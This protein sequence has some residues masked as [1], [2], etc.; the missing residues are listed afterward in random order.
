MIKKFWYILL[1]FVFTGICNC[2][3]NATSSAKKL[4]VRLLGSSSS[5]SFVFKQIKSDTD[6]F[7]IRSHKNKIIISG[8][9]ANSMAMGLGYYIKHYCLRD[10]SWKKTDTIILPKQLPQ[11]S[12]PFKRKALVKNRFFLNY[13]TFGYTMVWWQW[14]DWER[15]ID[16]MAINGINLPLAITGQ[17]SVWYKVWRQLGLSDS[18]IRSYFTGPAHLP[19]HRMINID[20]WQGP[21]PMSWLDHQE[22]LQRRIVQRERELG[23]RPILPAFAGHVPEALKKVYPNA[24]ISTTSSW[25]G[26]RDCY[27]SHFLDPKDSLFNVIQEKFLKEQT[28]LY[29]TDHIYGVDPF[30]EIDPPS[31][32]PS[33]LDDAGKT[34]YN[35]LAKNDN[36]TIWVQM[37]WLFYIDQS[38]WTKPRIQA[39]LNSVPKGKLLLLDYFAENTEVW[40]I[41]DSYFGH[42]F[43]WC[44]LGNFGGNTML[45]GNFKETGQRIGTTMNTHNSFDGIGS[46]LE[47]FDC[48]PIM[49][50]YV[51]DKAWS[52][53]QADNAWIDSWAD[54][55]LGYPNKANREAWHLLVDSVYTH[56]A[57][58]G[59][60]PLINARPSFKG[61]GNWTTNPTFYY[62]NKVLANIL[63]KMLE[64][65]TGSSEQIRNSQ[66]FDLVN[67]ARQYLSNHFMFLRD[68]FSRVYEKKDLNEAKKIATEMTDQLNDLDSLLSLHSY[69][70]FN[71]W[72]NDSETF[73]ANQEEKKYYKRSAC[74]LLTSWGEVPQSLNDYASR[75]WCGLVSGYY[76]PRWKMFL[77]KAIGS[78]ETK[79]SFDQD[80]YY[81]EVTDFER[82]VSNGDIHYKTYHQK[83]EALDLIE[84]IYNKY[85]NY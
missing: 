31:W 36:K 82:N 42:P 73:A 67:I 77:D 16:W 75:T 70:S 1:L 72:I 7:E 34:I 45:V 63:G 53:V 28:K 20:Y 12:I 27:K 14:A 56:S 64:A 50:E 54:R 39:F 18:D 38:H 23:M 44:Y 11:V 2:V 32:E 30:N 57:A 37:T 4:T 26:F 19:W 24:K 15:F 55:R 10:I 61:H 49:Y 69:F 66:M 17:E 62:D 84:S 58:L 85:N 78:L 21:L 22:E 76:Y 59:Q 80:S 9:N 6:V 60:A 46:T 35:S 33:F 52:H 5:E 43:I 8:N 40:K 83:R 74:T 41:T 51:F 3:A 25:G 79:S 13:C 29:G 81:K 48:N 68:D 71:D 65:T 47:G